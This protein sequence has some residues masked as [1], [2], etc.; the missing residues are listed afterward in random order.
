MKKFNN[1]NIL[2]LKNRHNTK[3]HFV[4]FFFCR[5]F[6]QRNELIISYHIMK[7]LKSLLL[8]LNDL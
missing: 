3:L 4:L 1:K 7:R 2:T 6:M 8:I 5:E